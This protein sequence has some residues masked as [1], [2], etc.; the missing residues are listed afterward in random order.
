M[1]GGNLTRIQNN[2][3]YDSTIQA[4]QKIASG[5]ITGNLLATNLTL[6][7]NIVILG[8]LT[9]LLTIKFC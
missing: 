7:S 9:E 6:N 5:S 3:I 2:Q 4:Q 1:S 8:N